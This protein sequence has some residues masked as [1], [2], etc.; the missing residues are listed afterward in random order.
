MT[1]EGNRTYFGKR[2]EG[3]DSREVQAPSPPAVCRMT[4][5][6]GGDVIE[7]TVR[8]GDT[9]EDVLLANCIVPDTVLIFF[10]GT[11]LPQD[12]PITEPDVEIVLTCSRG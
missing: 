4:I 1:D 8:P 9:Y 11:S 2:Q 10:K 6:P 3:D 12:K 5:S 7:W